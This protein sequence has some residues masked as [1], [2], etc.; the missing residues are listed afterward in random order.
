[1]TRL[2]GKGRHPW[3]VAVAA[4]LRSFPILHHFFTCLILSVH[5][6]TLSF[7]PVL[8]SEQS[9]VQRP[10]SLPTIYSSRLKGVPQAPPPHHAC[11]WHIF[12]S[13]K[14]AVST[15]HNKFLLPIRYPS[16]R[17]FI[18]VFYQQSLN[19]PRPAPSNPI[20]PAQRGHASAQIR[21]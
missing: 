16:A 4:Q 8:S 17:M 9:R 1:M 20:L 7:C 14:A 2:L 13:S 5:L 3:I 18:F 15:L 11:E 10:H 21:A 12:P 6:P 19:R